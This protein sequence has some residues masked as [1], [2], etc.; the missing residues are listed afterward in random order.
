[1]KS[2]Q[3]Y[4]V[5]FDREQLFH[6]AVQRWV[7]LANESIRARNSFHVALAGGSTPKRVYQLLQRESLDWDRIHLYWGDERDVPADHPDSNYRMVREALIDHI[8][9]PE[10]NVHPI[11]VQPDIETTVEEYRQVLENVHRGA[12]GYPCFDLIMLGVGDDGHIASLFP[13]SSALSV[14]DTPVVSVYVEKL[15][16]WRVT[17]TYPVLNTA[18]YLMLLVSGEAKTPVV[19]RVFGSEAERKYPV[20]KLAPQG[21][22]EWYLD[23][24]AA[25]ELPEST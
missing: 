13:E 15:N 7:E 21:R 17:L 5:Y 2:Q 10:A 6:A 4:Q 8:P 19:A 14:T 11:H 20:Q 25:S 22:I 18:R 23:R 3:P 9:I 1:M 12:N 16:S 24:S